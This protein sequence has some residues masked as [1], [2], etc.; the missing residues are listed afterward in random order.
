[1]EEEEKEKEGATEHEGEGGDDVLLP[2]PF[3]EGVLDGFELDPCGRGGPRV[4]VR[5]VGRRV[6]L[7]AAQLWAMLMGHVRKSVE[8]AHGGDNVRVW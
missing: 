2:G 1:M 4:A 5:H 8:R 7:T 3:G 6:D